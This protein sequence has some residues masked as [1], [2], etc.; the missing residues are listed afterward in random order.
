MHGPG[1]SI[2]N[3]SLSS[4][5][6][7]G[8]VVLAAGKQAIGIYNS[9]PGLQPEGR[10]TLRKADSTLE[11]GP[12]TKRNLRGSRLTSGQLLDHNSG[13]HGGVR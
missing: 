4:Q 12:R 13:M 3:L 7:T 2:G 1:C 8:L 5:K 10:Q 9:Q 11:F 6:W